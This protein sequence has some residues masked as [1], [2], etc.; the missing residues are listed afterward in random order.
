MAHLTLAEMTD[1]LKRIGLTR[2]Y[3]PMNDPAN[4]D[5]EKGDEVILLECRRPASI[6]AGLLKGAEIDIY[7]DSTVR[8]WTNQKTKAM[9][10]AKSQ[11][12]RIRKLDGE[13]ELYIP[14]A[15]ADHYLHGFGAKVRQTKVMSPEQKSALLERFAK[16]RQAR[17][18]PVAT[19]A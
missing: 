14:T 15:V 9:A 17:K 2:R 5:R 11:G 16:A 3:K 7:D 19:P 13:A 1:K 10:L 12:F 6:V 4:N 8:V 18:V